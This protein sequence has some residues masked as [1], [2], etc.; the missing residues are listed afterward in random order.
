MSKL[1]LWISLSLVLYKARVMLRTYDKGVII[2]LRH[3][4]SNGRHFKRVQKD[5]PYSFDLQ[6]RKSFSH[7]PVATS[8]ESEE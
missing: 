2:G 4:I 8:S 1:E 3:I 6:V 5:G 7:A